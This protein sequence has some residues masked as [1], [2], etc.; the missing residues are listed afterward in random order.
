MPFP[1]TNLKLY[2]F[3]VGAALASLQTHASGY[4][5]GFQSVTAL[6][7]ANSSAAEAVDPSTIFHNPAGLTEV[8]GSQVTSNLFLV[9]PNAKYSDAE[10]HYNP[11]DDGEEVKGEK[12]G[13]IAHGVT[14]VPQFYASHQLNDKVALGFGV[15]VPFA[16]TTDY[17][18]QSVLRYNINETSLKS[19]NF[20]PT[21]AFKVNNQHSLG[22]GVIA[23]YLDAKLVKYADYTG[24]LRAGMAEQLYNV[25][26]K[27]GGVIQMGGKTYPIPNLQV[28]RAISN[29]MIPHN[30]AD[31]RGTIKG[32]DWAFGYNLGWLWKVNDNF[33][34]GLSYR[35]KISHTLKGSAD[36][37]LV[38]EF[39]TT[40]SSLG[41]AL[42]NQMKTAITSPYA[43][44]TAPGDIPH[45]GYVQHEGVNVKIVTPESLSLHT[46]W[47]ATP[48]W[49][50]FGNLT[51][52]RHSRLDK[53][54][55]KFDSPKIV[56][57]KTQDNVYV[58]FVMDTATMHTKWRNTYALGLGASY[59]WNEALQLRFGANYDRSPVTSNDTRLPTMPD[60]DRVLLSA[61][62][63]YNV[64]NNHIINAAYGY[65]RVHDAQYTVESQRPNID[66]YVVGTAKTKTSAHIL[67]LQYTYK[68]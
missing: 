58:P 57:N 33:R 29:Q 38:G 17:G 51:W 8:E 23:Q 11:D 39:M 25:A 26:K 10:A 60:N 49:N 50:L 30:K 34:V 45:M 68:F 44:P 1:K 64:N 28:A 65:M 18:D 61:G 21:L 12:S 19:F 66:N 62:V 41:P 14:P 20:N 32:D 42:A 16:A 9:A 53:I 15:Y 56:Q 48:K 47:K 31:A 36:W 27:N 55:V 2:V 3:A 22:V 13:K 7:T 40:G 67:G 54:D 52:T 43:P 4:H 35:S 46:M 37:D 24:T 63:R 59:Q 6:S 5:F